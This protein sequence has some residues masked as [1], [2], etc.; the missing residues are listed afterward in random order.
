[1]VQ[2]GIDRYRISRKRPVLFPREDIDRRR[3]GENDPPVVERGVQVARVCRQN[4]GVGA[5]QVVH[6]RRRLTSARAGLGDDARGQA[7]VIGLA[8]RIVIAA[9]NQDGL[10]DPVVA[11]CGDLAI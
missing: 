2:D 6:A 3:A 8:G 1:M 9:D 7:G 4:H 5:R 10:Y 11:S